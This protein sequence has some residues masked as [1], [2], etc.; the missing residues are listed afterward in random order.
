MQY[1]QEM[2]SDILPIGG[3]FNILVFNSLI[4][5]LLRVLFFAGLYNPAHTAET[6]PWV[7]NTQCCLQICREQWHPTE[8]I[9][10][11]FSCS[12][13]FCFLMLEFFFFCP[14][15][16]EWEVRRFQTVISW[17]KKVL[18]VCRCYGQKWQLNI[19]SVSWKDHWS[20]RVHTFEISN[21]LCPSLT[22][23]PQWKQWKHNKV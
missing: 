3:D 5:L 2:P 8:K 13:S 15:L 7:N 21:W 23:I 11:T 12:Q 6:L 10:N 19:R 17:C 16:W 14:E 9:K 1:V 18:E 22:F 20:L 4:L